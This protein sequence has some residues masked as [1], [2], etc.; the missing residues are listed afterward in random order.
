MKR[1]TALMIAIAVALA[2]PAIAWASTVLHGPAGPGPNAVVDVQFNSKHGH[3]TKITRFEFSNI[4]AACTG[5]SPT[6]V[7]D[8]FSH[9]ILVASDG[10]FHATEK[11]RAGRTTYTVSG[12]FSSVKKATGH[13]RIKGT[14]T[15]CTSADSGRVHWKALPT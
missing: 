10:T 5:F 8:T 1:N 6:A 12:R 13:L 2:V 7:S 4:P 11:L 15:G 14:V 9:P 3:P